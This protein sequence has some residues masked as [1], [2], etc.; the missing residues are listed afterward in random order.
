MVLIS[1]VGCAHTGTVKPQLDSVKFQAEN[2]PHRTLSIC[3]VSEG[4]WSRQSI[5]TTIGDVSNLMTEQ[6]G[7]E[8]KIDTWIDHS[9]PSYTQAEGLK[10]L[11]R[12]VGRSH[13]ECDLVIGFSSRS[14]VSYLTEMALGAWLGAIDD[15]YRKFII[16]KYLDDRVLMH[17]I[18]HAFVFT[19]SHSTKGVMNGAVIK[20]PLAPVL[21]NLPRYVS[22]EDRHEILR[23][24]W[25]HFNE[26]PE[27]PE[28]FQVDTIE[29]L[30]D[31]S[32][33]RTKP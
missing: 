7:I 19:R 3:V 10:N 2:L 29:P 9:I 14:M 18:C 13:R 31:I 8:L 1:V 30:P 26:K 4:S 33:R 24:K 27:I 17:E 21:F 6:V 28:E 23:N 32:S 11:V 22:I 16:I 20:I 15:N 5:Q 12:I 25:R